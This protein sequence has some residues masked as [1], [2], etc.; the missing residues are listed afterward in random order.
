MPIGD[1]GA[2]MEWRGNRLWWLTA[3]VFLGSWFGFSYLETVIF[4]GM[5]GSFGAVIGLVVTLKTHPACSRQRRACRRRASAA[6][7]DIK[8][9]WLMHL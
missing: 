2:V 6:P 3:I 7:D 9:A 4:P 8:V 1:V 5:N